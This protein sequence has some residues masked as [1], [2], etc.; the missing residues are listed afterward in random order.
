MTSHELVKI[1]KRMHRQGKGDGN[2]EAGPMVI[3]FGIRYAEEIQACGMPKAKL[4]KQ[5]IP[6][7]NSYGTEISKGIKLAR[8]VRPL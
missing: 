6:D 3:L 8:Y 7:S 5:A 2:G 1:L 4:A